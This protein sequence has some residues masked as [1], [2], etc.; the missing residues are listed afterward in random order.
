MEEG[1]RLR[2]GAAVAGLLGQAPGDLGA[3]V[4][5]RVA[6][7]RGGLGCQLLARAQRREPVGD[8]AAIDDRAR[9]CRCRASSSRSAREPLQPV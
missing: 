4:L 2:G 3:A 9:D 8:R 6:Q 1:G 5:E 7:D